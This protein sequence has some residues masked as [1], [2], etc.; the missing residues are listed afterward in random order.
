ME[1]EKQANTLP[2]DGHLMSNREWEARPLLQKCFEGGFPLVCPGE[3]LWGSEQ[4]C[5]FRRDNRCKVEEHNTAVMEAF[6]LGTG[7]AGL[8]HYLRPGHYR[9][10]CEK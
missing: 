10:P 7:K 1:A 5:A 2:R 9:L 8:P 3:C 6:K 4:L